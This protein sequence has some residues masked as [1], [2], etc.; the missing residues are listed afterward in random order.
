MLL[1]TCRRASGYRRVWGTVMTDGHRLVGGE[2][3]ETDRSVGRWV[4]V[5]FPTF[6]WLPHTQRDAANVRSRACKRAEKMYVLLQC[7]EGQSSLQ[8]HVSTPRRPST[9]SRPPKREPPPNSRTT[10]TQ[11]DVCSRPPRE[12]QQ[13]LL[14]CPARPD[15]PPLQITSVPLKLGAALAGAVVARPP[16]SFHMSCHY[17]AGLQH[18]GDRAERGGAGGA[19][20]CQVWRHAEEEAS[21]AHGPQAL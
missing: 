1:A 18:P 8:A 16:A 17:L 7:E 19:A 11:R 14:H 3:C 15:R 10:S 2:V 13:G 4:A 9:P 12:Q 6:C 21:A 5:V 20:A